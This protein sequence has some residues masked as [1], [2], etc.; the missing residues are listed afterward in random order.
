MDTTTRC[1]KW[2][3]HFSKR[4]KRSYYFN[5]KTRESVWVDAEDTRKQERKDSA[6]GNREEQ[7]RAD[8]ALGA[9]ESNEI[10]E[11]LYGRHELSIPIDTPTSRPDEAQ[12]NGGD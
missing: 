12:D 2:T 6:T 9:T 8:P 3:L 4:K 7:D 1:G 5:A 11:F 10:V